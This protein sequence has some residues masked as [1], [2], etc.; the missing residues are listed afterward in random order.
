MGI[1]F[2]FLAPL[3]SRYPLA[4]PDQSGVPVI[5]PLGNRTKKKASLRAP[6]EAVGIALMETQREANALC[7]FL[8]KVS[9]I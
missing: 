2:Y 4:V 6:R 9:S 5:P 7:V 8:C 3:F 1:L